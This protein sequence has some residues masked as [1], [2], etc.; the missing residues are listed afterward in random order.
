M[1]LKLI[2]AQQSTWIKKYVALT[3][4]CS[5]LCFATPSRSATELP[6]ERLSPGGVALVDVGKST[7]PPHVSF[8]GV[9][10]L[11]VEQAAN[12]WSAVVGIALAAQ[13]GRA[14]LQVKNP[15][16]ANTWVP[17]EIEAFQ[18]AEQRLKVAPNQV[19]LSKENL[20]RHER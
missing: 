6:K 13:P 15:G 10:V 5:V 19:N 9:P 4:V 11:V 2:D 17:F 14:Q 7:Q 16:A 3:A 20:A 12:R 18:Y 8:N 1:F